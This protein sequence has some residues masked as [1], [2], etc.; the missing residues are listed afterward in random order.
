MAPGS[1]SGPRY[2]AG[3]IKILTPRGEDVTPSRA[4]GC[5][6]IGVAGR[7]PVWSPDGKKIAI[8]GA[9]RGTFVIDA[10]GTHLSSSRPSRDGASWEGPWMPPGGASPE[11]YLDR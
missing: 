2:A 3:K 7:L 1:P 6:A 10:D 11:M 4:G 8:V 5:Q 9:R